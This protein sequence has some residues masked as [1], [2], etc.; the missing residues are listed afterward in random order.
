MT[1][2]L[3]LL[4]QVGRRPQEMLRHFKAIFNYFPENT[5]NCATCRQSIQM[6]ASS[7]SSNSSSRHTSLYCASLHVPFRERCDL[8]MVGICRGARAVSSNNI[9][10][11]HPIQAACILTHVIPTLHCI[12]SI[13]QHDTLPATKPQSVEIEKGEDDHV[14]YII[15]M[16]VNIA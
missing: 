12:A 6:P 5:Y 1:R 10:F 7:N 8:K 15:I 11:K 2:L 14:N 3:L 13:R 16:C 9:C 4:A